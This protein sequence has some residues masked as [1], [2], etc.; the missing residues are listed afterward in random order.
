MRGAGEAKSLFRGGTASDRKILTQLRAA[1]DPLLAAQESEASIDAAVT[2]LS[3][4]ATHQGIS[5]GV[6]TRLIALARPD[7]AVSVNG[8][9]APNLGALTGL[10]KA[11]ASLGRPENYRRLLQWVARQP[12]CRSPKP[13]DPWQATLWS[14]RAALLDCFV[15]NPV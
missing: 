4:M 7:I 13:S 6:A 3:R 10:L 5:H 2:C 9:S 8:G 1:L 12:W 14:M 15:Y 11:P